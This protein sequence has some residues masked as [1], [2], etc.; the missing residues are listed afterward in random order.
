MGFLLGACAAERDADRVT[1]KAADP[2][3]ARDDS[4][5]LDIGK[6]EDWL[7]SACLREASSLRRVDTISPELMCEAMFEGLV[8]SAA[9]M[10]R[11]L[12]GGGDDI[13][14]QKSA[15]LTK[16]LEDALDRRPGRSGEPA[17]PLLY[18]LMA[19]AFPCG[20]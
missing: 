12:V 19:D 8:D 1:A 7:R 6:L 16:D 11:R 4:R 15:A 18:P 10:G 20:G 9:E 3:T 13:M 17:S 5:P 2:A 14:M